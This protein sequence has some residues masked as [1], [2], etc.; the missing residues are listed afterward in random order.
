M[1]MVNTG[2]LV[3]PGHRPQ[4]RILRCLYLL[5]ARVA[6]VGAPDWCCIA[7]KSLALVLLSTL[8]IMSITIYL[9]GN[10]TSLSG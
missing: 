6:C 2:H 8:V 9:V 5:E 1:E 3:G 7:C 4:S 10:P